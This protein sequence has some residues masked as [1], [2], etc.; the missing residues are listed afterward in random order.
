MALD[1]K[2]E[3]DS[4]STNAW[5]A[6]YCDLMILLLTFFVLL[7]SLATIDNNKKR[8]ALNSFVGAFGFKPG[9]QSVIG[10]PKGL[11]ITVGSAPMVKEDIQFERLRNV[12]LKHG[13]KSELSMSRQLERSVLSISNRVL[14]APN[15][16]AINE[17]SSE[18]L[19]ELSNVLKDGPKLI[20]IRGYADYSETVFEEDPFMYSMNLSSK[21][22]LAVFNLMMTKGGIPAEIMVAHGFGMN[23]DGDGGSS[24]GPG[25][26][27][28]V[29]LI[30]DY[31][32][33]VPY[34]LKKAAG[35]KKFLDFDGFFFRTP[36]DINEQ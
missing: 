33:E 36:G 7:L 15:E 5:M 17:E 24:K 8:L 30:L 10:N 16:Y 6:T 23:L 3:E 27:R 14:F 1:R 4:I 12:A 32:E 2:K 26:T 21:R 29:E 20:E 9:A 18:F 19:L 28:Q 11:N 13:L 31:R 25:I 34:R 22:A 35:T